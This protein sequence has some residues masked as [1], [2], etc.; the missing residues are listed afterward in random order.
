MPA[1]S[2]EYNELFDTDL[3]YSSCITLFIAFIFQK[4]SIQELF[5]PPPPVNLFK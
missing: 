1:E 3:D 4:F 2:T 5:A